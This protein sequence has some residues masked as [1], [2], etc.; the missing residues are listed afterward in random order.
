MLAL[1]TAAAPMVCALLLLATFRGK[2]PRGSL[3]PSRDKPIELREEGMD[4]QFGLR[5]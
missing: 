4:L 5:G 3:I 1:S 2:I